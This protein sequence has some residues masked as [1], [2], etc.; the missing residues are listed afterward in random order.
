MLWD[1]W[2]SES[3]RSC[4]TGTGALG[5][6]RPPPEGAKVAFALAFSRRR[7]LI[8]LEHTSEMIEWRGRYPLPVEA[9]IEPD[10]VAFGDPD[11][12]V[13]VARFYEE[14]GF[15]HLLAISNFGG[16]PHKQVPT[17]CAGTHDQ[18]G[19][20][21][22]GAGHAEPA[23]ASGPLDQAHGASARRRRRRGVSLCGGERLHHGPDAGS[24]WRSAEALTSSTVDKHQEG[25]ADL[26]ATWVPIR[27]EVLM[28]LYG[29]ATR[30]FYGPAECRH[31]QRRSCRSP[32]RQ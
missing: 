11:E 19:R 28:H 10:V 17:P 18:Q 2:V 6:G 16:L 24:R 31:R 29:A 9:L 30:A 1:T 13:R 3:G 5:R 21:R 32:P 23:A 27:S 25:R 8:Q 7:P 14:A 15:T 4:L 22:R 26:A 12:S 20:G